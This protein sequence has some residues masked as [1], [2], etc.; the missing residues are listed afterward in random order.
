MLAVAD[1]L[2][3]PVEDHPMLLELLA[4]APGPVLGNL[5]L[6]ANHHSTIEKLYEY[7]VARIEERRAEPKDDVL[8]GMALATFPDGS[9][10]EPIEV[11]RIASNLFAAGQETTVQLMGI[12]MQRI[13]AD[14][15]TCR[16]GSARTSPSSRSSSKRR[17]ASRRPSRARSASR[18]G[19]PSSVGSSSRPAPW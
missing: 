19:R 13:A 14:A 6:Q 16:S 15:A 2:G 3:V 1:L 11:A 9:V 17:C 4:S 7:F 10:P 18:S 12:C 5:Q 8:T